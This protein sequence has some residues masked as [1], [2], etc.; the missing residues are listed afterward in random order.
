M[1]NKLLTFIMFSLLV[2]SA[3]TQGIMTS[4]GAT[5]SNASSKSVSQSIQIQDGNSK[6]NGNVNS[7][8][9]S[10]ATAQTGGKADS[11]S[12]STSQSLGLA[13]NK[14]KASTNSDSK[15]N[16]TAIGTNG[17]NA[18][19]SSD[20]QSA[21]VTL[22]SGKSNISTDSQSNVSSRSEAIGTYLGNPIKG[23]VGGPNY[24]SQII[25]LLLGSL[26]TGEKAQ[27]VAKK[28]LDLEGNQIKTNA[29]T[30]W[31]SVFTK[32]EKDRY[33][34]IKF[35]AALNSDYDTLTSI[36]ILDLSSKQNQNAQ[37][38]QSAQNAQSAQN[39]NMKSTT[40][41]INWTNMDI[42]AVDIGMD[43]QGQ[44][45]A[46]GLDGYLY[47]RIL[48]LW[49]KVE[50]DFDLV[51][52]IRVDVGTDATPYVATLTGET[53]YL[54]CERKW[55]L[56]PGCARDIGAGRGGEV[57]KIGCV[58]TQGGFK[59]YK[60]ICQFNCET[61][62]RCIRYRK[63]LEYTYKDDGRRCRWFN[64]DGAGVRID[65]DH[66]GHPFTINDS[67]AIQFYN[68]TEWN[69]IPQT[70]AFDL[71]VSNEG[72]VNYIGS[73]Y[74]VYRVKPKK[75]SEDYTKVSILK[76]TGKSGVAVTTGPYAQPCIISDG[77]YVNCS[78][79]W[80]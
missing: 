3:L 76:L 25:D 33:H 72:I 2:T 36:P 14:S 11:D 40:I 68:G 65:V 62:K 71:S 15:S 7:D 49:V 19:S 4:P 63:R 59:I 44:L 24:G 23:K 64:M 20:S 42:V 34:H 6:A 80:Q 12:I 28:D 45:Y 54:S 16:S 79:K 9:A 47:E 17:G 37:N 41:G 8:S 48:N 55:V 61:C 46:V 39:G 32:T 43:S 18:I 56:L 77:Y 73:D 21:A 27:I 50:G 1:R 13:L 67:G 51:N 29:F 70:D 75:Y 69:L 22:A 30:D 38:S 26:G 10:V 60:L 53:Y 74:S 57:F 78:Y 31:K 58:R 5:V 66:R 52:I 35:D